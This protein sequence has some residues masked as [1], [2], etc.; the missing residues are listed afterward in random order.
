MFNPPQFTNYLGL[1]EWGGRWP[2]PLSQPNV[3]ITEL[4]S[5]Y[6]IEHEATPVCG[7]MDNRYLARQKRIK[8]MADHPSNSK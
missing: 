5:R 3:T 1:A 7:D 4:Y 6:V 2:V 8:S